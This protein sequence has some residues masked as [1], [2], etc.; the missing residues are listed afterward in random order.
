MAEARWQGS[1]LLL[2]P[3]YEQRCVLPG[4]E[5]RAPYDGEA[6]VK[7]RREVKQAL[8]QA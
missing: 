6:G 7:E 5:V 3:V 2:R 1:L 8:A 4:V